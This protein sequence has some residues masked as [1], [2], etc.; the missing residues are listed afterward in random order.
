MH[1]CV[2]SDD[3]CAYRSQDWIKPKCSKLWC[4][5]NFCDVYS[6][7]LCESSTSFPSLIHEPYTCYSISQHSKVM[8]AMAVTVQSYY[9]EPIFQTLLSSP[10]HIHRPSA[11]L[12]THA[13]FPIHPH[14]TYK[15]TPSLI[16]ALSLSAQ[17]WHTRTFMLWSKRSYLTSPIT[18]IHDNVH[19]DIHAHT[20]DT[21]VSPCIDPL[22]YM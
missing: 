5:V 20:D 6:T 1:A 9:Y 18:H 21:N 11:F 8:W 2:I 22:S 19:A 15:P 10:R 13:I 17:I 3:S 14:H 16:L 4:S 7:S 12:L